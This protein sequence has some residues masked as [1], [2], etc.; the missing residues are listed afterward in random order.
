[1]EYDRPMPRMISIDRQNAQHPVGLIGCLFQSLVQFDDIGAGD[2][3][4]LERSQLRRDE[5]LHAAAIFILSRGLA[6]GGDMLV[7][8][9]LAKL[10]HGR[11]GA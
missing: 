4:D 5:Q 7:E 8:E 1:M 9:P 3:D 6:V 11:G 10:F 2:V